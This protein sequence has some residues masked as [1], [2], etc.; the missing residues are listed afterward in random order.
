M[1]LVHPNKSK[2]YALKVQKRKEREGKRNSLKVAR[3]FF[4]IFVPSFQE[5]S[6][7]KLMKKVRQFL[8]TYYP[9][10]LLGE[11]VEAKGLE[12]MTNLRDNFI[13]NLDE[14]DQHLLSQLEK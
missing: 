9:D 8:M 14:K 11:A 13:E 7:R 4:D 2:A 10:D 6:H 12:W 5:N 3:E 1:T